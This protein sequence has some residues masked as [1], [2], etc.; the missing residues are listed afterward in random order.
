MARGDG[1]RAVPG[2]AA[3]AAATP[4][5]TTT[6]Q[7]GRPP[8]SRN[9]VNSTPKALPKLRRVAQNTS[10]A[11]VQLVGHALSMVFQAKPLQAGFEGFEQ[12]PEVAEAAAGIKAFVRGDEKKVR[13]RADKGKGFRPF[14]VMTSIAYSQVLAAQLVDPGSV[15]NRLVMLAVGKALRAWAVAKPDKV[16]PYQEAA[17]EL[18]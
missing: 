10:Q 6:K 5:A 1:H 14:S 13:K 2:A 3:A 4:V 9:G 16:A 12:R 11:M 7:R 18:W 17:E 15:Q 8:G